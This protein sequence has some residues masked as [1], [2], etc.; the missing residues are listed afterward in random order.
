MSDSGSVV[1]IKNI[2]IHFNGL[3]EIIS[4]TLNILLFGISAYI[5]SSITYCIACSVFAFS[6]VA[7]AVNVILYRTL[8]YHTCPLIASGGQ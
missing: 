3:D 8:E 4:S 7:L 2:T 5:V 6:L 1:I